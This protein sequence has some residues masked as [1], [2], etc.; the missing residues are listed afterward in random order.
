MAKPIVMTV[1]ANGSQA[2]RDFELTSQSASGLG[3]KVRTFGKVFAGGLAIAGLAAGKFAIDSVKAASDAQQSVGA[4]ETV[5]GK[6]SKSVIADSNSAARAYGLSANTYR[7][8]ANIIGSLFKNQGVSTDKLAS[9]TKSM[10]GTASDL[11]ATFGGTTT[12]A[13]EA[14]SSAFKGEFDPLEKYGISIKQS[15]VNTEAQRLATEK[16]HT[17]LG[18]L[19][20][21]QQTALKQQ[22]TSNLVMKQSRSSLGAF[23][24]E[25]DTLAHQ[26]QVLGAQ[27]D[28]IK[29]KVGTYLLPVLTKF[30]TFLNDDGPKAF[31]AVSSA[32]GPVIGYFQNFGSSGVAASG[33][34]SQFL[35][36]VKSVWASVQSI[37][38]SAVTIVTALWALFG[39][40]IVANLSSTFSN[41]LLI[42]RG[43]FT[44]IQGIFDVIAG[45]LTGDW[46]RVWTGIKEILRGAVQVLVG[47]VRQLWNTITTLFKVAATTVRAVMV[48]AWNAITSAVSS[49]AG[50]V[51][52]LVKGLPG[53][54]KSALGNLGGLLKSAGKAVIQ[55]LIDGIGSMVNSLK[56][57]LHGITKLIPIHKGPIAKDRT[58]LTSAG[59]AIMDGLITGI[60]SKESHLIRTLKGVSKTVA[61]TPIG[62]GTDAKGKPTMIDALPLTKSAG[63]IYNITVQLDSSM[64][65]IEMGVQ[66]QKAINAAK[67]VGAL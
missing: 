36:T 67:K 51:V 60:E 14:L 13:V 48:G 39:S 5:F 47:L 42:L 54:M 32:V 17:S 31:A 38:S 2:R 35:T 16:Y 30:L 28:N 4:T 56:N 10:I 62:F 7:E 59:A 23:K 49:G 41:V 15:T 65:E 50:K 8:N 18:K 6:F 22:A 3:S 64:T 55:G 44:V 26:Q 52:S 37:F 43:A 11:A 53:K 9:K 40:T 58:L 21:A 57:K 33:K 63:D 24:G 34:M 19:S 45:I 66:M 61:S 29:V 25:T 27:F 46:S 1:L 12:T 20:T